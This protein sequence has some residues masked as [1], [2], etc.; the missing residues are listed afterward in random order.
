MTITVRVMPA[1]VSTP[2]VI[3]IKHV[4]LRKW[5]HYKIDQSMS[6]DQQVSVAVAKFI[7]LFGV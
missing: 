4:E 7:G 1:T 6:I 2:S 3:Q 5:R